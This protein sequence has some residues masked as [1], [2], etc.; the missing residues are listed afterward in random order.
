[1]KNGK[2]LFF[3]FLVFFFCW[4]GGG[5]STMT[6]TPLQREDP[7]DVRHD[8]RVLDA[9]ETLH[10]DAEYDLLHGNGAL[11]SHSP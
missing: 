8:E 4:G 11:P 1:M 3:F 2:N 9:V 6:H 7:D 10:C 5:V